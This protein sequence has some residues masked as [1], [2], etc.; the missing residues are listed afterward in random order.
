MA[1]KTLPLNE[2]IEA[3]REEIDEL[4]DQRVE[5]ERELAPGVPAGVLRNLITA[6]SGG[7]ACEAWLQIAA[8]ESAA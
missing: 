8:K 3:I 7:C 5:A 1:N 4:I 6:R 2:R